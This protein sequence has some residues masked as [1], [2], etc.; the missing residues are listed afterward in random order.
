MKKAK[1]LTNCTT[2]KTMLL[3]ESSTSGHVFATPLLSFFHGIL[4]WELL[5]QHICVTTSHIFVHCVSLST[6]SVASCRKLFFAVFK[7]ECSS[8]TSKNELSTTWVFLIT[9]ARQTDR[10]TG[11]Y[12]VKFGEKVREAD[13]WYIH[14]HA[15]A[16]AWPCPSAPVGFVTSRVQKMMQTTM[17]LPMEHIC[18][19]RESPVHCNCDI[20]CP[21]GC[22]AA[23]RIR[24]QGVLSHADRVEV[25]FFFD[26]HAYVW[27][28][29]CDQAPLAVHHV[30]S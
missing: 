28:V 15:M 29:R 11:K 23:A 4:W 1:A 22:A 2:N 26:D 27:R 6:W 16:D 30:R 3:P 18:V 7:E 19:H 5:Q 21:A 24:S 9:P 8:G 13:L 17:L 20:I 10:Q 14:L 12:A 25:F